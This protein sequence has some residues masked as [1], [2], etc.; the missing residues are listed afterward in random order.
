MSAMS[1]KY[2]P[3]DCFFSNVLHDPAQQKKLNKMRG[4]IN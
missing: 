3:T 4:G 2:T 1:K